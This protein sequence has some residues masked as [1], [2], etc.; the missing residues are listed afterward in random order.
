LTAGILRITSP[1]SVSSPV[2]TIG[3]TA[4]APPT[5]S[6]ISGGAVASSAGTLTAVVITT[7]RP[8]LFAGRSLLLSFQ[9]PRLCSQLVLRFLLLPHSLALL[10]FALPLKS[11]F[12]LS[13]L[14]LLPILL[15]SLSL[16]LT[17]EALLLLG[18]GI[19]GLALLEGA[20]DAESAAHALILEFFH[21]SS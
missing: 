1:S 2:I 5:A 18:F 13:S 15:P 8:S 11:A 17:S 6:V 9:P 14:P 16:G 3:P 7:I 21:T 4:P 10:A 20:A 19:E 12:S